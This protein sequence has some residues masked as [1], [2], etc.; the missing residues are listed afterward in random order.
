MIA[1]VLLLAAK[2][3]VVTSPKLSSAP[4]HSCVVADDLILQHLADTSVVAL[5]KHTLEVRWRSAV[6]GK[7]GYDSSPGVVGRAGAR[8]VVT[9]AFTGPASGLDAASGKVLWAA[10]FPKMQGGDDSG[11]TG[12]AVALGDDRAVVGTLGGVRVVDVS[13]GKVTA[14]FD[15]FAAALSPTVV[16]DGVVFVDLSAGKVR[17]RA[18]DGRLRWEVGG[19]CRPRDDHTTVCSGIQVETIP[20]VEENGGV[21]GYVSTNTAETW[22]LDLKTGKKLLG[23]ESRGGSASAPAVTGDDLVLVAGVYQ[24]VGPPTIHVV[25]DFER[26]T[27]RER[28]HVDITGH[29]TSAAIAGDVVAVGKDRSVRL[30]DR[31]TGKGRGSVDVKGAVWWAGCVDD[32]DGAFFFGDDSRHVTRIVP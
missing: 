28:W 9:G 15:V 1:L 5:D 29:A 2:A 20:V 8:V 27:A 30:Y 6:V 25:T 23:F 13:S 26:T 4:T 10:E 24:G 16:D 12:N 19:P 32:D 17:S 31:A 14:G 21:T 3:T 7:N 11:V 22:A 18:F